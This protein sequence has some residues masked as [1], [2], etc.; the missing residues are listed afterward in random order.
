MMAIEDTLNPWQPTTNKLELALLGKLLE[1][2]GEATQAVSRCIIQGL[3]EVH[4]ITNK[5]N[6]DAMLEELAD[7][8][9]CMQLVGDYVQ[10]RNSILNKRTLDKIAYLQAWHKLLESQ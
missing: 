8:N 4:P 3:N 2:L 5:N 10:A 1:E 9:A 7:V 6:T